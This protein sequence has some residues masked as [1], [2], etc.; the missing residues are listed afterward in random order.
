MSDKYYLPAIGMLKDAFFYVTGERKNF[1]A[2]AALPIIGLSILGTVLT[3]L[4][5]EPLL[6]IDPETQVPSVNMSFIPIL[7]VNTLLY[8]MFAVAWHRKWLVGEADIT[9]YSALKWDTRKTKFLVRLIQIAGIS[10]GIMI[11]LNLLISL[12]PGTGGF[13]I[14]PFGTILAFAV[15]TLTF[16]RLSLLFPAAAVDDSLDLKDCWNLTNG[17]GWRL[18]ILAILPPIPL[19]FIQIIIQMVLFTILVAINIPTESLV[20]QL[21]LHLIQHSFNY[22]GIAIGVSALSM[23]YQKFRIQ[24]PE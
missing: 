23:A 7:I 15:L 16:A 3:H 5:P 14:S 18:G 22:F 24:S 17:N 21:F 13:M 9:I 10:F 19:A 8:V 1:I 20:V 11:G 4:Y 2:M 12:L 6:V